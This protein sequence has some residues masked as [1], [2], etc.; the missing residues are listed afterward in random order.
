MLNPT[1][2]VTQ[3]I[4]LVYVLFSEEGEKVAIRKWSK[5][6]FYGA[7]VYMPKSDHEA[8]Q[9]AANGEVERLRAALTQID[10]LDHEWQ[11]IEGLSFGA[12]K[13]L[14]LRMGEI[15][16]QALGGRDEPAR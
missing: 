6:P 1:L 10:A 9:A 4:D 15:A 13:G 7:Q 2:G 8:M 14:I 12:A 16:R 11:H 3:M 5:E